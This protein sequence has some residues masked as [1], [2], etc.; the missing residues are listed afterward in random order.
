MKNP[1]LN[2]FLNYSLLNFLNY[3]ISCI[4]PFQ[5]HSLGEVLFTKVIKDLNITEKEYVGLN[6]ANE[7]G[8]KVLL[9]FV[10]KYQKNIALFP[11]HHPVET[12]VTRP[13]TNIFKYFYAAARM[14]FICVTRC[15]GNK[16]LFFGLSTSFLGKEFIGKIIMENFR[17]GFLG[18]RRNFWPR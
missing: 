11:A 15:V 9:P 12:F 8:I 2:R 14:R 3:F 7:K 10:L 13:Q 18:K 16:A 4:F 1:S 5:R 17:R 6:F